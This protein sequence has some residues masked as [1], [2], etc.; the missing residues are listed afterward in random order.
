MA[1][2]HFN[3]VGPFEGT[4]AVRI[5]SEETSPP[6]QPVDR[7]EEFHTSLLIDEKN[8]FQQGKVGWQQRGMPYLRPRAMGKKRNRGFHHRG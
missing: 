1:E 7:G 2:L 4:E 3:A 8:V 6:I 5:E